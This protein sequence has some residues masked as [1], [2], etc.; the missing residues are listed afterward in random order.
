MGRRIH[1]TSRPG[2]AQ[3]RGFTLLELVVVLF[4]LGLLT[5]SALSLTGRFDGQVRLETTRQRMVA[6]RHG[7]LGAPDHGSGGRTTGRLAGYVADV[8][9]LPASVDDLI[10][11]PDEVAER[12]AV[13]PPVFDPTPGAAGL[14][15]ASGDEIEL[16]E[17]VEQLGKGWRGPYVQPPPAP[18]ARRYRDGWGNVNPDATEDAANHGWSL[19]FDDPADSATMTLT[20]LGADG[21]SGGGEDF[22]TDLAM[23]VA[24]ADWAVRLNGWSLTVKNTRAQPVGDLRVALLIFA[25]GTWRRVTT[26]EKITVQANDQSTI[27]FAFTESEVD[28]AKD[29]APIG[30]HLLVLVEDQNNTLGDGE[31]P[32]PDPGT[33]GNLRV[34]RRVKFF[35]RTSLPEPLLRITP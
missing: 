2:V 10:A 1:P 19:T 5:A 23:T 17:P 30:E 24:E 26:D 9:R 33:A 12:F 34:T 14:E 15:D 16:D 7:L 27:T 8:G 22:E 3:Y 4:I 31:T 11:E 21:K 25:N 35:A 32:Y 18:G 28:E 20:S 6:L 13:R 29:R